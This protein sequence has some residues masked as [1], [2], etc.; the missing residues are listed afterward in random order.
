MEVLNLCRLKSSNARDVL[1]FISTRDACERDDDA[2]GA[3]LLKVFGVA[4]FEQTPGFPL[5]PGRIQELMAVRQRREGGIVR[6]LELGQ[7]LIGTYSLLKPEAANSGG[8][9]PSAAY[10]CSFAIDMSVQGLGLAPILMLDAQAKALHWDLS[11]INLKVVATAK[12]L[13]RL[14]EKLGFVRDPRGDGQEFG[15]DLLG[16]TCQLSLQRTN[17]LLEAI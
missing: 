8:W 3:F 4:A 2:L 12:G 13:H 9:L 15:F 11:A 14:Y 17:E 7:R 5:L 16:Y 10:F 1:H 6:I